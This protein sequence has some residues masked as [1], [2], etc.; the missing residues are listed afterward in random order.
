MHETSGEDHG[1]ICFSGT[2][3]CSESLR[4]I[5][6]FLFHRAG[7]PLS[8]T[9]CLILKC[10]IIFLCMCVILM[11]TLEFKNETLINIFGLCICVS[12]R[13]GGPH[14]FPEGNS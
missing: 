2:N 13:L 7:F 11:K 10:P 5:S 6:E 12:K 9:I 8:S 3:R 1:V 4:K 14:V